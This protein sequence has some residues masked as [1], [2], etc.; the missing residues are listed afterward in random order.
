MCG[1]PEH[2]EAVEAAIRYA[3]AFARS[4]EQ[5][6]ELVGKGEPLVIAA[7]TAAQAARKNNAFDIG[8][9]AES[10]AVAAK[11][12]VNAADSVQGQGPESRLMLA[13]AA[14]VVAWDA[15]QEMIFSFQSQQEQI[16]ARDAAVA[17]F[18]TLLQ[19]NLGQ[20]PQAGNP[21]VL[22]VAEEDDE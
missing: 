14:A 15:V 6:H 16:A 22:T 20:Y 8:K 1:S 3:E 12:A 4:T 13:H 21:A 2:D 9:A 11:A 5:P 17:D 19:M 7:D 10:A 18:N